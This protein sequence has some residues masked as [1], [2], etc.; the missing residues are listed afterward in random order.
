MTTL[1]HSGPG[2]PAA[3]QGQLSPLGEPGGTGPP[4]LQRRGLRRRETVPPGKTRGSFLGPPAPP[5]PLL[6]SHRPQDG[7]SIESTHLTHLTSPLSPRGRAGTRL[8]CPSSFLSVVK[9]CGCPRLAASGRKSQVPAANMCLSGSQTQ[10]AAAGSWVTNPSLPWGQTWEPLGS[11]PPLRITAT[12]KAWGTP[13]SP[14]PH[15]NAGGFTQKE[16]RARDTM[17]WNV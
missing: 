17:R 7:Q 3:V 4:T 1:K 8:G 15:P 10:V 2:A 16:V 13:S 11:P 5:A 14:P 6:P 9:E 12:G